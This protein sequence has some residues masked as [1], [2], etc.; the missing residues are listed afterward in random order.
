ML[1]CSRKRIQSRRRRG[2]AVGDSSSALCGR[3]TQHVST[4]S[5]SQ[6]HAQPWSYKWSQPVGNTNPRAII[7][8]V[9]VYQQDEVVARG[10]RSGAVVITRTPASAA[11]AAAEART[12]R[13]NASARPLED[14]LF[15]VTDDG[16]ANGLVIGLH[17]SLI[18]QLRYPGKIR[19]HSRQL[20]DVTDS[21]SHS[22]NA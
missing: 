3:K 14:L 7:Q 2:R 19:M 5:Y 15:P 10:P 9:L 8:P 18:N 16:S 22:D 21:Q 6:P 13:G 12:R 20:N 1:R 4:I 17:H 11:V